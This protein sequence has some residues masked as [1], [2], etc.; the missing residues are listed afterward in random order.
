MRNEARTR[1]YS[2]EI[3]M[4]TQPN[5]PLLLPSR[6][7]LNL[8]LLNQVMEREDIRVGLKA[9][10]NQLH[11]GD[12]KSFDNPGDFARAAVKVLTRYYYNAPAA[13]KDVALPPNLYLI[14]VVATMWE[15]GTIGIEDKVGDDA[16]PSGKKKTAEEKQ[17]EWDAKRGGGKNWNVPLALLNAN[18]FVKFAHEAFKNALIVRMN[19][20]LKKKSENMKM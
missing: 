18:G 1:L 20:L 12:S 15:E 8:I 17:A 10:F 6:F 3:Q 14:E 4:L 16:L 2:I 11:S 19:L 7:A 13:L 9:A 5:L